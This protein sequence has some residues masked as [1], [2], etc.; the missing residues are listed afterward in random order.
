[1]T[2][3]RILRVIREGCIESIPD[4]SKPFDELESAPP[5]D[6]RPICFDN[7][8]DGGKCSGEKRVNCYGVIQKEFELECEKCPYR[9][10]GNARK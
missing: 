10:Q 5:K 3:E 4:V 6:W 9:F 7:L 1:M 8:V 2:E